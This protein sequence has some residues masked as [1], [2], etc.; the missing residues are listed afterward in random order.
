MADYESSYS[1][2]MQ[3]AVNKVD[4][5]ATFFMIKVLRMLNLDPQV[6]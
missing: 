2:T 6:Y 1:M 3:Q 5:E 4:Q